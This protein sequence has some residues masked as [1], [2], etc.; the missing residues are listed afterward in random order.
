MYGDD[1]PRC[2]PLVGRTRSKRLAIVTA[3]VSHQNGPMTTSTFRRVH[4]CAV[5]VVL[6][7]GIGACARRAVAP[8]G[9][10]AGDIL[11]VQVLTSADT[12]ARY[13]SVRA[14]FDGTPTQITLSRD[15]FGH[16][17]API[18]S[19]A[20]T[21]SFTVAVPEHGTLETEAIL[22]SERPA[23]F[24]I[25]PRPVF[26]I[27]SIRTVRV[28]GDFNQW[29]ARPRDQLRPGEDGRLR[30]TVPF[31]GDSSRF[32][33]RGIGVPSPA[34]WMP[35]TRYELAPENDA[36]LSF[37]GIV[38]PVRDSLRFEI[39]TALLRYRDVPRPY[40]DNDA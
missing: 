28:V 14:E 13:A 16:F 12:L 34:V 37:A 19:G 18:P 40:R 39:D 33:L 25:R 22:P 20:T 15:A 5:A 31:I 35:V 1:Q 2:C 8:S 30:L 24:R 6:S 17:V 3:R 7:L 23:T 29:K 38:R 10:S 32:Q 9:P 4:R 26:P 11:R 36:E 21:V 27:D